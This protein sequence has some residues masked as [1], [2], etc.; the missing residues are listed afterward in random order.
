M[1]LWEVGAQC[2]LASKGRGGREGKGGRPGRG[3]GNGGRTHFFKLFAS[4]FVLCRS[5]TLRWSRRP[6]TDR[7]HLFQLIP[8]G[9]RATTSRWMSMATALF[10]AL[11]S[12]EHMDSF[13]QMAAMVD[14]VEDRKAPSVRLGQLVT[15]VS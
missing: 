14:T 4:T 6:A 7:D 8:V 10:V 11:L 15:L 2:Q 12:T 9:G 13:M 5:H 1:A 3:K